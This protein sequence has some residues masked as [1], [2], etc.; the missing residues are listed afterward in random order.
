MGAVYLDTSAL[1]RV[2]LDE[3][4]AFE[5]LQA[6]SEFEARVSSWLVRLELRRLALRHGALD[7]AQELLQGIALAPLEQATL[8]IAETIEPRG[9]A[10][11]DA[12]HLATAVRMSETL[13]AV[14]TYDAALARGAE[15]HGLTVLA[16]A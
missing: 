10:T 3:P 8:G 6:L 9:I 13:D 14:M 12:I 15:H 11:L 5:V 16:P 2:L 1:G 7:A 4:G